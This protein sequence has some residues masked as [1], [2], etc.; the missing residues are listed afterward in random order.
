MAVPS[1]VGHGRRNVVGLLLGLGLAAGGCHKPPAPDLSKL[2]T[3][4]DNGTCP[5]GLTPVKY[6]GVAGPSGPEFCS[7]TIPCANDPKICPEKTTCVTIADGPGRVC[8]GE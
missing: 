4:C 8:S 2:N 1:N 5:T 3:P 6:F 7:C